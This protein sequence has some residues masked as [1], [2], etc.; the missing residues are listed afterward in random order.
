M[1]STILTAQ[2]LIKRY[3]DGESDT[4]VLKGIDVTLQ[5]GDMVALLG[6]SGSGKSTLLGILGLLQRASEGELHIDGQRVDTLT[7][8]ERARI[9]LRKM[10]FVFQFHHL[11]PDFSALENVAFP[12]A[13]VEGGLHPALRQRAGDLLA[14][15]GLADMARR[16]AGQLSGGQKQR[17]AIAR[18]LVA[19]P[20][21]V[22]G[23][24]PTGNLDRENSRNVM[25]LLRQINQQEGTTFLISTHDP[26]IA[27]ACDRQWH[28][29]DGRLLVP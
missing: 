12:L 23:D 13:T 4:T 3:R 1:T 16:P 7:E 21:L 11:L 5:R 10:G 9:R 17:V 6:P 27:A 24:E 26:E 22:F 18:A 20:L 19:S 14:A 28:V 8:T 29:S 15:V 25:S 2:G